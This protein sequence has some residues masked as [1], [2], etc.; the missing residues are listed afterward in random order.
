MSTCAKSHCTHHC[1]NRSI[2]RTRPRWSR[3]IWSARATRAST[4]PK[5]PSSTA[6]ASCC[7]AGTTM[8]SATAAKCTAYLKKWRGLPTKFIQKKNNLR[9][10]KSPFTPHRKYRVAG[11]GEWWC[12]GTVLIC[13]QQ[14][15]RPQYCAKSVCSEML[16]F[17][18]AI[19]YFV[20]LPTLYSYVEQEH[21][22]CDLN[23]VR[24]I[25]RLDQL[26]IRSRL[27]IRILR[28]V[29]RHVQKRV[30]R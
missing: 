27:I 18:C 6:A 5:P 20:H 25:S 22:A 3:P 19:N 30:L 26:S 11:N 4:T 17:W 8:N 12:E 10:K 24:Q 9:N 7:I 15:Y 29:L 2:T 28:R 1:A 16:V 23:L 13:W 21:L 14:L